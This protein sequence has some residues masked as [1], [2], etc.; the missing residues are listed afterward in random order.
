MKLES[1]LYTTAKEELEDLLGK[2]NALIGGSG[3]FVKEFGIVGS[4]RTYDNTNGYY[5][6]TI[7][8]NLD[9]KLLTI[10]TYNADREMLPLGIKIL[11]DNQI[12]VTSLDDELYYLTLTANIAKES[13]GE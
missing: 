5:Y 6:C 11:N 13:E 12:L 7:D 8:H 4:M 1:H 2:L 9:T 10:N 3:L